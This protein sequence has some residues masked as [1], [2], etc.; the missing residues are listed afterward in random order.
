[1]TNLGTIPDET[2]VIVKIGEHVLGHIDEGFLEKLKPGDIFVLG[3]N[4]YEFKFARGMVAQVKAAEGRRPT[5]PSWFSEMLP[6]SFDLALEIQKFRFLMEDKFKHKVEKNVILKFIQ[7]YL[8]LDEITSEAIYNYFNEQYKYLEIPNHKKI[9]VEHF[10]DEHNKYYILF[11]SLYGRRVNDVLSRALAFAIGRNQHRDVEV[12]I[13]DN[14]FY[15][16]C[17]KRINALQAF[18]LIKSH[19]LYDILKMSL[20][21]SEVLKRRFRH[22]A[23]RAF[24]ILRTY[25]GQTKRVGK[26]QVSSMILMAAVKRISD[27]FCILKEARREVLEDLMDLKNAIEIIKLIEEGKIEIKEYNTKI[28]SPFTFSLVLE[29][30]SDIMKIEER[31]EFLQRMHTQV[32][33]KISLGKKA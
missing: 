18:K 20:D 11:H 33:A 16:S 15:V 28:P 9:I 6:L 19:Q 21:K 2:F 14:G 32:R 25:K 5:I 3:G 27:E 26:Q 10:I 12:G 29:G 24:M 31:Q 13:N 22:C 7:D 1:M 30:Y 17:E 4:T 8:Y 23:S